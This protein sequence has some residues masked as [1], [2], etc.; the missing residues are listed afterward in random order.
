MTTYI[1]TFLCENTFQQKPTEQI[2]ANHLTD[3]HMIRAVPG[4]LFIYILYAMYI[5]YIQMYINVSIYIYSLIHYYT[6]ISIYKYIYIYIYIYIYS[7]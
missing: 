2:K 6:Y 3:F 5:I 1:T 7:C 4:S